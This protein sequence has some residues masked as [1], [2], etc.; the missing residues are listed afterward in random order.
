MDNMFKCIDKFIDVLPH[1]TSHG[2]SMIICL[3]SIAL[4]WRAIAAVD[5]KT[6]DK[7]D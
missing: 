7:K 5:R 4:A 6:P 1:I 3:A 2:I